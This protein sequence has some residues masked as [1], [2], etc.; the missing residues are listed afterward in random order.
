METLINFVKSFPD[1]IW[2]VIKFALGSW[3]YIPKLLF[4]M[5]FDGFCF[6]VTTFISGLDLSALAFNNFA[7]WINLPTQAIYII[8]QFALP[9]CVSI[10]IGAILIRMAINLIPSVFTRL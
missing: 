2:G 4:F 7:E 5:T 1:F 3:F 6:V 8:N 9:Q 10:I